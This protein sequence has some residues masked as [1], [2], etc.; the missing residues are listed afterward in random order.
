MLWVSGTQLEI[1]A[2][3]QMENRLLSPEFGREVQNLTPLSNF[4]PLAD[5]IFTY[6]DAIRKPR[7]HVVKTFAI[8]S[9]AIMMAADGDSAPEEPPI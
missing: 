4:L 7:K 9:T 5:R 3:M 2:K 1:L 6:F 8:G